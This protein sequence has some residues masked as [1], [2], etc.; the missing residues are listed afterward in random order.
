MAWA[1]LSSVVG[2]VG[3]E[4]RRAS[5]PLA[6]GRWRRWVQEDDDGRC[7]QRFP[8]VERVPVMMQGDGQGWA[9]ALFLG[10]RWRDLLGWANKE[11]NKREGDEGGCGRRCPRR[12]W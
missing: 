6:D 8:V 12:R 2:L 11:K 7:G 10:R 4:P 5:P 3:D 1:A 9:A